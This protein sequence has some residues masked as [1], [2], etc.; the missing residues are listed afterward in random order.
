MKKFKDWLLKDW[1]LK[2]ISI[3]LAVL[4]WFLWIQ[5]E[6]PTKSK[7]FSN[8]KVTIINEDELDLENKVYKVLDNSDTVRVTVTAPKTVIDSLTSEDI[9]A[10]ADASDM[11]DG[12]I[13]IKLSLEGDST[14]DSMKASGEAI[15]FSIEDRA[16]KYVNLY[17]NAEG[18]V[19]ENYYYNGTTLAQNMIEISGPESEVNQVSY[20]RVNIDI[21]GAS[22]SLSANME[23]ELCDEKGKVLNLQNV[24]KQSDYVQVNVSVLATK[25]LIV[26][27]GKTG[28]PAEGYIY[29][30]KISISPE[31]IAVAGD[32]YALSSAGRISITDPID[33]SGADENV[34]KVVDISP[35]L[36]NDLLFADSD[37]D[38][39][40]TVT[41][42]VEPKAYKE[43]YVPGENIR[44]TG[45][46]QGMEA[47]LASEGVYVTL[48]G[49]SE[50]LDALDASS[51]TAVIDIEAWMSANNL[52]EVAPGF[53]SIPV[54]FELSGS[55]KPTAEAHA[56]VTFS[57]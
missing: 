11:E 24:K 57:K 33:I 31:V 17:S 28:E 39:L 2:I 26:Y 21:T 32:S 36:P 40:A 29:S 35:Y 46:P 1:G 20:G 49:L 7:D 38:G 23:I 52:T 15:S 48:S 56:Q 10:E 37:F 14:Y 13:P 12:K 8:I 9:I 47:A 43:L 19:A 5:I 3:I 18:E 30:G 4:I 54:T 41:V 50:E 53:H 6:N 55:I 22:V 25:K 42:Y 34:E 16:R 51:V 44:I 27:A 45:V